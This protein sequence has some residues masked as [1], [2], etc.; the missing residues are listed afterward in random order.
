MIIRRKNFNRWCSVVICLGSVL[1]GHK[2]STQSIGYHYVVPPSLD[3]TGVKKVAIAPWDI[4]VQDNEGELRRRHMERMWDRKEKDIRA[5]EVEKE[6]AGATTINME[7]NSVNTNQTSS[8]SA[9]FVNVGNTNVTDNSKT[10]NNTIQNVRIGDEKDA[11]DNLYADKDKARVQFEAN[12]EELKVKLEKIPGVVSASVSDGLIAECLKSERGKSNSHKFYLSGLKTNLIAFV[13]RSQVETIMAEQSFQASGLVDEASASS[14]G[15]LLGADA[16][17]I[18]NGSFSIT[19]DEKYDRKTVTKHKKVSDGKNEKGETKYKTVEVLDHY[20]HKFTTTRTVNL[21]LNLKL[22]NVENGQIIGVMPVKKALQDAKTNSYKTGNDNKP[23]KGEFPNIDALKSPTDIANG[24]TA[25]IGSDLSNYLTPRF[26]PN[27]V[28]IEKVKFKAFKDHQKEAARYIKTG[29][30]HKAFPIYKAMYDE[31]PYIMK[32]IYNL[33]L[34]YEAYGDYEN[35]LSYYEQAYDLAEKKLDQKQ[36]SSG[37]DRAEEGQKGLD[38]L[39]SLGVEF[40]PKSES[41]LK[42]GDAETLLAEKV[43]L[44]G[45]SKKD[46]YEVRAEP[47]AHAAVVSK[48]PGGRNY[49]KVGEQDGWVQIVIIKGKKVWIE[50]DRVK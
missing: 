17:I 37:M 34:L 25:R 41:I 10:T 15:A 4:T 5:S 24:A 28:R 33:G 49:P 9:G 38:M 44:R 47:S 16:I 13:E 21:T 23:S 42:G 46:R 3:V 12:E 43:T 36:Y 11:T 45:N 22:V 29:Q 39:A 18:G 50:A 48:V 31:E 14:L 40:T 19:A 1:L 2:G 30:I 35:A 6:R 20:L 27:S 26:I 7:D 8:G 32:S